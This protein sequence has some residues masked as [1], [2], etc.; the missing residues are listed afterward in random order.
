MMAD[1]MIVAAKRLSI[2]NIEGEIYSHRACRVWRMLYG[3][4]DIQLF[5]RQIATSLR[6]LG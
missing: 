2:K 3:E 5:P 4:A 6:P 1:T